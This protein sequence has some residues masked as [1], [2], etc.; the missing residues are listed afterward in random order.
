M[1]KLTIIFLCF[2]VLGAGVRAIKIWRP[3]DRPSW[4]ECDE[5]GIAR[6]Y[7]REGMNLFYPR[8]DWRG[9]TPGYAEMEF[10]I[11]PWLI[12]V[13]YKVIGFYEPIGRILSYLF[14]LATLLLFFRLAKYLLSSWGAIYAALF[15]ALSPLIINISSSLQP[16]SLMFLFY[17]L[18]GYWFIRWHEEEKEKYFWGSAVAISLAI[19]AKATAAHLGLF[20]GVL[21]LEKVGF[22][23][24]TK[25]RF[26]SFGAVA[27]LP[28]G[29][30]YYHAHQFWKQY[31]LSLGLSNE[32][33]WV[34]WDF[35]T[36]PSFVLGLAR[37]EFL[38]VLMPLGMLVL[39]FGVLQNK[40]ERAVKYGLWWL[41]AVGVYYL[42]AIR[43]TSAQ[44]AAY[45]HI[46]S[47]PAVAL[48]FGNGVAAIQSFKS[49]KRWLNLRPQTLLTYLIVI[50]ISSVFLFQV[51]QIAVD[52]K[53]WR[54]TNVQTCAQF[55][56]MLIPASALVLTTGG[57]CVNE[58]G[59]PAAYNA[60]FMLYWIDRKGFNVCVEEQT[61]EN[62]TVFAKRGAQY[63]LAA[64]S[65]LPNKTSL[66]TDLR[67]RYAVLVECGDYALFQLNSTERENTK[68]GH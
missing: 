48:L 51:R 59:Y 49:D 57:T 41:L 27:L 52:A 22:A 36:N 28:G 39:A 55:F 38:Y 20:F 1:K 67:S 29:L 47:V 46:V 64:K 65:A 68:V 30:W 17:V 33:H 18:A 11:Y 23:A 43:T 61:L 53:N 60:S 2:F 40:H 19:L 54:V 50:S 34:G 8:V 3:V 13:G 14:S 25:I 5:A 9:D 21:I 58:T 63:Y 66:E 31:Q 16:E 42:L 37:T 35:F 56:A 15:F 26:W 44:W 6:N 45:Y 7:Y 24:L 4:R 12:A 10:P 62:I 32:Y